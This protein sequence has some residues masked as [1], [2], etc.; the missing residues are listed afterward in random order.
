MAQTF[1]DDFSGAA[2]TTLNGR[3]ISGKSWTTFGAFAADRDGLKLNGIGQ[4]R[5]TSS[6]GCL[7]T[8]DAGA[9]DHYAEAVLGNV[10]G[11]GA[12]AAVAVRAVDTANQI[13]LR[14]WAAGTL[15][16][17]KRVAGVETSLATISGL[18]SFAAGMRLKLTVE[19]QTVKAWLNDV[20]VGA[21]AGYTA[22]DSVFSGVTR[23]GIWAV[24]SMD[25][26]YDSIA[27]GTMGAAAPLISINEIGALRIVQRSAGQTTRNLA[28]GGSYQNGTPAAIE[29]QLEQEGAPG[30]FAVV[31]GYGWS[32]LV[33]PAIGGGLWSGNVMLPQGGWYRLRVRWAGES[34]EGQTSGKFAVGIVAVMDGQSNAVG[35]G[36][37]GGSDSPHA[38]VSRFDGTSWGA[39]TGAGEIALLNGIRAA[40]GVP[41]G[42]T[43]L[44]VGA[45]GIGQHRPSANNLWPAKM[46]RL[47]AMGGDSEAIFWCQGE[48]D[49]SLTAPQPYID[50]LEEIYGGWLAATGRV[51][52]TLA[53]LL[54]VTGRNPGG[55]SGTDSGWQTVRQ[56]QMAWGGTRAGARISH[57]AC[58]LPMADSLHYSVA[59]YAEAGRRFS[60]SHASHL[61][62]SA[63][64]GRGPKILSA[65][66]NGRNVTVTVDLRG[67]S[68][69]SATGTGLIT[70]FELSVDGFATKLPVSA[71]SLA[72]DQVTLT[73][74]A[75]PSPGLV[76]RHLYGRDPV[77]SNLVAGAGV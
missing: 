58:D 21:A 69:L 3:S 67:A 54:S 16:L 23:A 49:A 29:W 60:M 42:L 4:A 27:A 75:D 8:V 66:V 53:F 63:I 10:A 50:G 11:G 61:G 59:G 1:L 76:L 37:S 28:I 17:R 22:A 30:S 32:A 2:T 33:A 71:S 73:L 19:G 77:V 40:T 12:Y 6:N 13:Y 74:A 35:M 18:G 64:D 48:N 47:A 14:V 57:F 31:P 26:V 56:A 65:R 20:Q 52:A 5:N 72:G 68:G 25:P 39:P 7:A 43:N 41:V 55:T 34:A 44:G 9:A 70:G 62:L 38:L 36:A 46:T 45:T 24:G 51:S 15:S